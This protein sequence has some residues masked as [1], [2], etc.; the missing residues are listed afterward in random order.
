MCF[1]VPELK[2]ANR[3]VVVRVLV[4]SGLRVKLAGK[5]MVTTIDLH[6]R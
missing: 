5:T 3:R 2:H 4:M 6:G 1:R